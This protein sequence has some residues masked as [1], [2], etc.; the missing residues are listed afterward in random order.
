MSN[1]INEYLIVDIPF[2]IDLK[3]KCNNNISISG[4]PVIKDTSSFTDIN[5]NKLFDK[6]CYFDGSSYIIVNNLDL[7]N[8]DFTLSFWV[9]LIY[10]NNMNL[11]DIRFTNN[12]N[13]LVTI[14]EKSESCLNIYGTNLSTIPHTDF[15]FIY[16]K[17]NNISIMYY[18]N[19]IVLYLNNNKINTFNNLIINKDSN[20]Y[21]LV[22][23]NSNNLNFMVVGYYS[24]VRLYNDIGIYNDS[25]FN[26]SSTYNSNI[27]IDQRSNTKRLFYFK[28]DY[29]TIRKTKWNQKVNYYVMDPHIYKKG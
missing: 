16:N 23:A 6:A 28:Y 8:K 24:N 18:N 9:Y 3:D 20:K 19:S 4:N 22:I 13:K 21:Q 1:N 11:F 2:N 26:F 15:N 5:G 12:N 27:D 29:N 14:Y 10:K 7:G 25:N 17:W